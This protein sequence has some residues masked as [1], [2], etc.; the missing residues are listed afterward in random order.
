MIKVLI[1]VP[2]LE[3]NGLARQ[4][5]RLAAGLNRERF[6]TRLCILDRSGPWEAE[7]ANAGVGIEKLA[8]TRPMDMRSIARL[9]RVARSFRPH[10]VHAH[11]LTALSAGILVRLSAGGRLLLSS[12]AL[13]LANGHAASWRYRTLLRRA[14]RI[15]AGGPCEANLAQEAGVCGQHI[16]QIPPAVAAVEP[17]PPLRLRASLGLPPDARLIACIGPLEY[18]KGFYNAIWAC[19]I[20]RYVYDN[21]HLA[22]L[23]SGPDEANLRRL[24]RRTEAVGHVHFL[25]WREDVPSILSEV[26]MVW[27]PSRGNTGIN[28]ILEA[29]AAGRPVVA[30]RQ[31]ALAELVQDGVT[32]YLVPV[33]DQGAIARQTRQILDSPARAERM[34]QAARQAVAAT[35]TPASQI[36][37]YARLYEDVV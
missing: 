13:N 32:G 15:V 16:V 31:P 10:V 21:V 5:T 14:D 17:P 22:F 33:N 35:H 28:A 11:G 1:I 4:A 19:D 18:R 12:F 24:L 29:M 9:V 26:D 25:G 3:T 34:G 23:G 27:A 20:L 2:N 30:T 36:D 8:W 37:A 7:V 6:E